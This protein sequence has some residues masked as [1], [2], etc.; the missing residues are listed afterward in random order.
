[1]MCLSTRALTTQESRQGHWDGSEGTEGPLFSCRIDNAKVKLHLVEGV[2]ADVQRRV[3][4]RN[5]S[6]PYPVAVTGPDRHLDMP[7]RRYK[8]GPARTGRDQRYR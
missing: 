5:P 2:L 7:S 6:Q 1:M 3:S 8:E 4:W